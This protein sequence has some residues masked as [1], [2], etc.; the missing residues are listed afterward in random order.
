MD[1]IIR[2]LIVIFAVMAS[3]AY[4]KRKRLLALKN[5]T[6]EEREA[7][8]NETIDA[9]LRDSSL[10]LGVSTFFA[11]TATTLAIYGIFTAA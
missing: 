1:N 10:S 7:I 5:A 9:D 6:P 4:K 11:F 3:I 2:L 8:I